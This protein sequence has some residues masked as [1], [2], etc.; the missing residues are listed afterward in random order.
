MR[1]QYRQAMK[2]YK[3]LITLSVN[4][5]FLLRLVGLSC[6]ITLKHNV[7]TSADKIYLKNIATVY[8]N[9]LRNL[10]IANAPHINE[11]LTLNSKYIK[12]LLGNE[13]LQICGSA[14]IVKRKL[15]IITKEMVE[16]MT[17]LH[18]IRIISK[19]PIALPYYRYTIKIR[20]IIENKNFI[21]VV[22]SVFKDGKLYKSIG[23]SAKKSMSSVFPVAKFDITRGEKIT[24]SKIKFIKVKGRAKSTAFQT[25]S[26]IVGKVAISNIRQNQFFTSSNTKRD[27]LVKRGDIVKVDVING[28]IRISTIAKALHNGFKSDIIPIMYL[29]SKRIVMATVIGEKKVEVQ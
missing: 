2:C 19:M 14:S 28:P 11:T 10:Y 12:T 13:K 1:K 18:N 16:N 5:F 26:A 21:W 24:L 20:K 23:I 9:N 17:K 8:P 25:P 29:P 22:L 27:E 6:D 4:I 3:R 15:F 7:V